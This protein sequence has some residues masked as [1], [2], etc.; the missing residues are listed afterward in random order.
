MSIETYIRAARLCV[1]LGRAYDGM[2][3]INFDMRRAQRLYVH[4]HGKYQV[5]EYNRTRN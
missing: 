1:K 3:S 4:A 5:R 2:Y